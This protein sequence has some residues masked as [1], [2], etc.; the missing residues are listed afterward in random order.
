MNRF[1]ALFLFGLFASCSNNEH[2]KKADDSLNQSE[3]LE[4]SSN[5]GNLS[6]FLANHKPYRSYFQLNIFND[7]INH[8]AIVKETKDK[9]PCLSL[10][11]SGCYYL[12]ISIYNQ[13]NN[14]WR[15]RETISLP[16]AA[17]TFITTD[18]SL[19]LI[20]NQKFR[21]SGLSSQ[22]NSLGYAFKNDNYILQ[23]ANFI[24][25]TK[26]NASGSL[27]T[28]NWNYCVNIDS[29]MAII[30]NTKTRI[31]E[32]EGGSKDLESTDTTYSVQIKPN[33]KLQLGQSISLDSLL[34]E[35][36]LIHF[37]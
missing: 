28:D 4:S 15:M 24:I 31:V 35:K 2:S 8:V 21:P 12:E 7:S 1:I 13:T 17:N 27:D 29:K 10:F 26:S 23:K 25:N 16:D 11:D 30:Q 36:D 20:I 14:N 34:S 18:S 22:E 19:N 32:H 6:E 33:L 9:S 5:I 3:T 37:Y